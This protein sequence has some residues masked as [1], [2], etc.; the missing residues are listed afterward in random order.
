[1]KKETKKYRVRHVVVCE[2]AA[3]RT[4]Y[5]DNMDDAME[6]VAKIET[7]TATSDGGDY[8]ILSDLETKSIIVEE[9]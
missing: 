4:I 2:V 7:I 1:M 9:V 3:W 5:A 8:E 6:K